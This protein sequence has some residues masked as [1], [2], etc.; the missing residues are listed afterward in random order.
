MD[1]SVILRGRYHAYGH[2]NGIS[3]QTCV[4]LII[5]FA[6]HIPPLEVVLD[7]NDYMKRKWYFGVNYHYYGQWNRTFLTYAHTNSFSL[8]PIITTYRNGCYW[9]RFP[10]N[11]SKRK[12]TPLDILFLYLHCFVFLVNVP[13]EGVFIWAWKECQ[14][15][16]KLITLEY[17]I[18]NCQLVQMPCQQSPMKNITWLLD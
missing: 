9:T 15:S 16:N 18:E 13:C 12:L 5:S 6:K 10:Q 2:S 3:S 14:T 7:G 11:I 1:L 8:P 17:L 4:F